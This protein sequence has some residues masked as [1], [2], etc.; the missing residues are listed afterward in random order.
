MQNFYSLSVLLMSTL[1]IGVV[2]ALAPDH[3]VP[4]VS[5]GRA[6]K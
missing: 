2:H 1:T 5:V 4:F 6:Q 3:W